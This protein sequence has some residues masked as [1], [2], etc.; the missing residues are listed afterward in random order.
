MEKS[1]ALVSIKRFA[2]NTQPLEI[3]DDVSLYPLN[4]QSCN[5]DA[6]SRYSRGGVLCPFN[7]VVAFGNLIFQH[8]GELVSDGIKGVMP[9]RY[10]YPILAA[11]ARTA[12]DKGKL[13][14]QGAVEV[15]KE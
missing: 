14:E 9:F 13:K 3:A 15:V 6:F 10:V 4:P 1:N 8:G 11:A 2:G 5:F 7:T 12:V